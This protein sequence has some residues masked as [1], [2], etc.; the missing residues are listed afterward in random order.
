MNYKLLILGIILGII[1]SGLSYWIYTYVYSNSSSSSSG[2]I[3]KHYLLEGPL[4]IPISKYKLQNYN[5]NRFSIELWLFINPNAIPTS[6]LNIFKIGS[7][8]SNT[9][10]LSLDFYNNTSLQLTLNGNVTYTITPSFFLQ[11]WEQII[12]SIDQYLIDLYLDGKL[13]QSN[14]SSNTISIPSNTD[15]INFTS[16]KPD[17]DIY[18]SNIQCKTTAMNP[19][20]AT[21]NYNYGK[22]KLNR[23]TQINLVLSK[24]ENVSKNFALF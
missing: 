4:S 22:T 11:K 2:G 15:I 20:T 16:I 6:S 1:L 12:I 23:N 17:S 21:K 14:I 19:K 9:P 8:N 24:N 13:I 18:V 10:K 7:T 3:N 5:A